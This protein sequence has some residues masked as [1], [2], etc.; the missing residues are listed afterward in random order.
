MA[1]TGVAAVAAVVV[2]WTGWTVLSVVHALEDVQHDALV[3][4]AELQGG[5][6]D[7]AQEAL[8]DYQDSAST[9]HSRTDGPTWWVLE[10]APFVGDDAEAV[11]TAADVLDDLGDDGIP[12]LV[13]AAELV[14]ARSFTTASPWPP[15]SPS[16]S[17][18][19]RASRR[20]TTPPPGCRASTPPG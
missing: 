3:L 11:A 12:Q 5:D 1:W 2:I 16:A 20:S 18:P 6:A 15:S 17:L 7:H 19:R 8:A 13:D 14:A 10:H 9:A 4:R